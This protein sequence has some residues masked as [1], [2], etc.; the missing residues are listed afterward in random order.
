MSSIFSSNAMNGTPISDNGKIPGG[1]GASTQ[2]T[3]QNGGDKEYPPVDVAGV[4]L[5]S[6]CVDPNI[7]GLLENT[8]LIE[9]SLRSNSEARKNVHVASVTLSG[10]RD[11]EQFKAFDF[12]GTRHPVAGFFVVTKT[13]EMSFYFEVPSADLPALKEK[14]IRLEF[15][16][17]IVDWVKYEGQ[18]SVTLPI[19][20]PSQS[21]GM[22]SISF[23]ANGATSGSVPSPQAGKVGQSLK[24]ADNTNL[25]KSG[26]LLG[27]WSTSADGTGKIYSAGDPI[28]LSGDTPLFAV[29]VKPPKYYVNDNSI[30]GD[31]FTTA[32]G[33]DGNDGT[34]AKPFLTIQKAI[35]AANVGD[36]ILVDAGQYADGCINIQ[37]QVELRGPNWDVSPTWGARR[38]EATINP[39][40]SGCSTASQ[41]NDHI[42]IRAPN[43]TILGFSFTNPTT[44]PST[45][46]A[47]LILAG[48][49]SSH[50]GVP[51]NIR[52]EKNIFNN[53]QGNAIALTPDAACT[54]PCWTI[55]DNKIQTIRPAINQFGGNY[56]TAIQIGGSGEWVVAQNFIEDVSADGNPLSANG[57][58]AF[59]KLNS[60]GS[61]IAKLEISG[62]YIA[63]VQHS[64]VRVVLD[65]SLISAS[66]VNIL[67]NAILSANTQ[68]APDGTAGGI[69]I[70]ETTPNTVNPVIISKN[71]VVNTSPALLSGLD[72][73]IRNPS[74]VFV[75]QNSFLKFTG[76][77]I[78]H[79]GLGTLQALR[80]WFGIPCTGE[81]TDPARFPG[82][83]LSPT[84]L[85]I[86]ECLSA[87]P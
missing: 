35:S 53:L 81:L 43:V 36:V 56:G 41:F 59:L 20:K 4:H 11:G 28:K 21:A 60:I 15:G 42:S 50:G 49:F 83:A 40:G 23:N 2:S 82:V 69:H 8:A 10:I 13:Q 64:A 38:A 45:S 39:G 52:I 27:G 78:V 62:N 5:T 87:E 75:E 6:Q 24:V 70:E 22:S 3:S 74:T 37:Q 54:G 55:V 48:T 17:A 71:Y 1:T 16:D 73:S 68:N 47:G 65:P 18:L 44:T 7:P 80:N 29:W 84:S 67:E 85:S 33:N 46:K 72:L 31:R 51:N 57:I 58:S 30:Q 19:G 61:P 77:P 86:T 14:L 32:A 34:S 12:T 9:C 66:S 26:F 79:K 63:Q 25:E 76:L